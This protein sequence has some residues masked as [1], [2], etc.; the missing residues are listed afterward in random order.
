VIDAVTW[1]L[2]HTKCPSYIYT[3]L[4]YSATDAQNIILSTT[5]MYKGP[6]LRK[7]ARNNSHIKAPPTVSPTS[8]TICRARRRPL[9]RGPPASSTARCRLLPPRAT[10]FFPRAP[11]ASSPARRW[12]LPRGG[13]GLP[14]PTQALLRRPTRTSS[15]SPSAFPGVA[16]VSLSPPRRF[17][18]ALRAPPPRLPAPCKASSPLQRPVRALSSCYGVGARVSLVCLRRP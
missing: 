4:H 6:I 18:A 17:S 3:G 9:S 13:A 16:L 2:V 12:R 15:Q 11:P 7:A 5:G 10:G 1:V 8:R 14:Q